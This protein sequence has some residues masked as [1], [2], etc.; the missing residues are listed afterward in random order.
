MNFLIQ[1]EPGIVLTN[2]VIFTFHLLCILKTLLWFHV[3]LLFYHLLFCCELGI[4]EWQGKWNGFGNM[5]G[6]FSASHWPLFFRIRRSIFYNNH[7]IHVNT[8][9]FM[10]EYVM[11]I[12]TVTCWCTSFPTASSLHFPPASEGADEEGKVLESSVLIM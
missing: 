9:L 1:I 5:V 12:R 6:N 4:R 8:K 3:V 7:C 10:K 2:V 11:D